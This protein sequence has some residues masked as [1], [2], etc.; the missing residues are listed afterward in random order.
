MKPIIVNTNGNYK[1]ISSE[2]KGLF[3]LVVVHLVLFSTNYLS[4]DVLIQM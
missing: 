1:T 2:N 3:L 4:C